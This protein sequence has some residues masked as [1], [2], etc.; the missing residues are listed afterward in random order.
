MLINL[1]NTIS[2]LPLTITSFYKGWIIYSAW[3]FA[4]GA[5]R[6]F[7]R[8][9]VFR[10][11]AL[12]F[13]PGV[14]R[15]WSVAIRTDSSNQKWDH[16]HPEDLGPNPRAVTQTH[17][18]NTETI[19]VLELLEERP[20]SSFIF[21]PHQALLWILLRAETEVPSCAVM[22][23]RCPGHVS[24]PLVETEWEKPCQHAQHKGL[25]LRSKGRHR[26]CWG[27]QRKGE[28]GGEEGK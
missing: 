19:I 27:W 16:L 15:C 12:P 26:R 28:G 22:L 17:H 3:E 13:S 14:T 18:N 6:R 1:A 9:H 4:L 10:F 21:F 25:V 20:S 23:L 24:F 2:H 8:L 5:S 7:R 11:S